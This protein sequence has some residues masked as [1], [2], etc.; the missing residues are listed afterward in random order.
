MAYK[1]H[2]TFCGKELNQTNVLFDMQEL[3]SE[4]Q[5][6]RFV[7]LKFRLKQEEL[8]KM[9]GQPGDDGYSVVRLTFEDAM[10]T[11]ANSNNLNNP[12]IARLSLKELREYIEAETKKLEK[13]PKKRKSADSLALWESDEESEE[14]AVE[15]QQ[16]QYVEPE[17]IRAIKASVVAAM[18]EKLVEQVLKEELQMLES[19]FIQ[20]GERS[21][22][23]RALY[24]KD[25]NGK[26]VLVGCTLIQPIS[27]IKTNSMKRVCP[28]CG[29]D[30]GVYAFRAEHNSVVFIGSPAAGKTSTIL[31]LTHYAKEYLSSGSSIIWTG[32][33]K[34]N[35]IVDLKL[36]NP[37]EELHRDLRGYANGLAPY[38]TQKDAREKSY[39]STFWIKN[40]NGRHALLTLIDLPGE[41]FENLMTGSEN[42]RELMNRYSVSMS[43]HAYI[44]CFDAA[45]AAE[46]SRREQ[47]ARVNNTLITGLGQGGRS[48]GDIVRE[49][50]EQ[51]E[52]IQKLRMQE[53]RTETFVPMMVLYTKCRELEE[54][55]ASERVQNHYRPIEA[56]YRFCDEKKAIEDNGIYADVCKSFRGNDELA[57]AYHA[58]LRCSP[59]GYSA[60]SIRDW[61]MVESGMDGIPDISDEDKAKIISKVNSRRM[62]TPHHIDDLMLWILNITGSIPTEAE[63]APVMGSDENKVDM[64]DYFIHR[65]QYRTQKPGGASDELEEALARCALFENP[66]G[67]DRRVL[68]GHGQ[69]WQ[70][71]VMRKW[72]DLVGRFHRR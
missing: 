17:S 61:E 27:K 72:E 59:Y 10:K 48:M 30:I 31:A 14:A 52:V 67:A 38:R 36:V 13:R 11:I 63:Y 18:N 2:C 15:E 50:S 24:E 44:V 4:S 23:M 37:S 33:K 65:I 5:D 43:C 40:R 6:K 32:K 46:A 49:S 19:A 28:E 20:N 22:S 56:V 42:A 12:E 66:S 25:D 54:S 41:L 64:R 16:V 8:E 68:E 55:S 3:L 60:P 57:K 53:K 62:P 29:T 7:H 51:A 45:A 35:D 70:E 34:N 26:N 21:V 58:M 39:S 47:E 71:L 1:Y 69:G 9:I